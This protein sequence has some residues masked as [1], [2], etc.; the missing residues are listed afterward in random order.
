M[1]PRYGEHQGRIWLD[2]VRYGDT[3]GLHFDNERSLWPYREYVINAFNQNKPF[4]QFTIEQIGG[5]LLPDATI[6]QRCIRIQ[7]L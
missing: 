7:S 5:D 4:D 1:S 2:A 6:D 3:H